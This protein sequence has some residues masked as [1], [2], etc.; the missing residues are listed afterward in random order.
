LK[1]N[2][3]RKTVIILIGKIYDLRITGSFIKDLDRIFEPIT[4]SVG[5]FPVF[6]F[7]NEKK[8]SKIINYK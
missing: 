5:I 4:F 3:E 6:S 2:N 8:L 7:S 1:S